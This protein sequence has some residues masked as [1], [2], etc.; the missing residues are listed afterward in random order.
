MESVI[1]VSLAPKVLVV[2]V[3]FFFEGSRDAMYVTV[4]VGFSIL[5]SLK[6]IVLI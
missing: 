3:F 2:G 4:A 6:L 1:F 5:L